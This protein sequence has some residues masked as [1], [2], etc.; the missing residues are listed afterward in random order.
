M[1][2]EGRVSVNGRVIKALPVFV[3]PQKDRIVVDGRPV[4]RK[5][6]RPVYI[7]VNKPARV[8]TT[9]ADEPGVGR[10]T[11]LDLVDHPSKARLFPVGRLDYDTMGLVLLT[12][13]GALANRLTHP[14]YGVS[15]TYRA[16]VKGVLDVMAAMRVQKSLAKEL[17]RADRQAGRVVP[18][19]A[20]KAE[21]HASGGGEAAPLT[22]GE[23][24]GLGAGQGRVELAIAGYEEDRTVLLITLREG[25]AGSIGKMLSLAGC[26]VRKLERTAIGPLQLAG[27]ARGRWR[28]LERPEVHALKAAARGS[29][30][31]AEKAPTRAPRPGVPGYV[32][33]SHKP[34]SRRARAAARGGVRGGGE[35]RP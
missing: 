10:T 24:G 12:N 35:G 2:E 5:R 8:L 27:V 1:I 25:R 7:M 4:A 34:M 21:E 29:V 13:D 14:S 23:A 20:A 18:G 19:A 22:A 15:K 6:P 17:R 16:E 33:L 26:P 28:E 31:A 9:A 32:P 30:G 11:V 3:D